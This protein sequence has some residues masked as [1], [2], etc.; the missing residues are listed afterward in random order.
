MVMGCGVQYSRGGGNVWGQTP[1]LTLSTM[2][3]NTA[4]GVRVRL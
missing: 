2:T 4:W 3:S 1:K